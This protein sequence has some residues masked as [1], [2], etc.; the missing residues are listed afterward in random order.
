MLTSTHYALFI[1][2]RLHYLV[3]TCIAPRLSPDRYH[4]KMTELHLAAAYGSPEICTTI[5]SQGVPVDIFESIWGTP[6]CAASSQGNSDNVKLLL[7]QGADVDARN[8]QSLTSLCLAAFSGHLGVLYLLLKH[9]A[10]LELEDQS[11]NTALAQVLKRDQTAAA[12]LLL[13]AH[14]NANH[15]SASGWT[16]LHAAIQCGKLE[17]V[18][19]FLDHGGDIEGEGAAG[20]RPLHI[21][22]ETKS[23]PMTELLLA[24]G[25]QVDT[26]GS[27]C[28]P[29][30]F[31][32]VL[33]NDA[34][35]TRLLLEKGAN[36][37][38]GKSGSTVFHAAAECGTSMVRMLTG[39]FSLQG[40]GRVLELINQ[41]DD[42][43]ESPLH[44]AARKGDLETVQ[45]LVEA[46][47]SIEVED[48]SSA[49]PLLL[50]DT[51]G[52]KDVKDYLLSRGARATW[53]WATVDAVLEDGM[54]IQLRVIARPDHEGQSLGDLDLAKLKEVLEK[55]LDFPSPISQIKLAD[56]QD[57][58]PRSPELNS[59][60]A[61]GS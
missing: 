19:L 28:L 7:E 29:P 52:E 39:Y 20:A 49:T 55:I 4:L 3:G 30:I 14:A 27:P 8:G 54:E 37:T 2:Q 12:R 41:R 15:K 47:A 26:A 53:Q 40:S 43:G 21:A 36:V 13:S 42:D 35:L 33:A 60:N 6:L 18:Q 23:L 9:G 58:D 34:S 38:G 45:A 10:E 5:L 24:R 51:Q 44:Y 61:G 56:A 31:S 25:A 17:L 50:A 46:G 59:E 32:A 16:P 22:V 57:T 11:G 48:N 1:N